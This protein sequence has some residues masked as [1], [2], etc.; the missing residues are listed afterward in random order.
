MTKFFVVAK[1]HVSVVNSMPSVRVDD[2]F[3]ILDRSIRT[4]DMNY[5]YFR[6]TVTSIDEPEAIKN[7]IKYSPVLI[8][9]KPNTKLGYG[10]YRVITKLWDTPQLSVVYDDADSDFDVD[11]KKDVYAAYNFVD[12]QNYQPKITSYQLPIYF[13]DVEEVLLESESTSFETYDDDK[14]YEVKRPKVLKIKEER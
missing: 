1:V 7:A 10:V 3:K 14:L 13:E 2:R 9:E 12:I 11:E 8:T 5:S 4:D 6:F